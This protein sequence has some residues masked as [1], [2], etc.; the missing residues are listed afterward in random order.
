[1]HNAFRFTSKRVLCS[2]TEFPGARI[3]LLSLVWLGLISG[4]V[5]PPFAP[6]PL[7]PNLVMN[8]FAPGD[9]GQGTILDVLELDRVPRPTV[10]VPPHYP[11]E[12]R[13]AGITGQA[14]IN[15]VVD[16]NGRTRNVHA[17]SATDGRFA[18]AAIQCVAQWHFLPGVKGGRI[19][20]TRLQV[21]IVF[22]ING[23]PEPGPPRY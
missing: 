16:E 17:L 12:L 8:A 15:F 14:V 22:A 4:C 6:E 3:R 9:E 11:Y 13:T 1:M 21:P 7:D 23:R 20:R 5:A 19:V 10:Q 18:V 2:R